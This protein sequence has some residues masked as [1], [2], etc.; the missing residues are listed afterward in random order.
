MAH[1][2]VTLIFFKTPRVVCHLSSRPLAS[3]APLYA[4]DFV[5]T[6]AH[7]VWTKGR[8]SC[9]PRSVK[10]SQES[11]ILLSGART[12][13]PNRKLRASIG[14]LCHTVSRSYWKPAFKMRELIK[15]LE[16]T[17]F[18]LSHKAKKKVQS[19][20]DLKRVFS[21]M[22]G[23]G[24]GVVVMLGQPGIWVRKAQAVWGPRVPPS[25]T[26]LDADF[27]IVWNWPLGKP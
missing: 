22:V 27:W 2:S 13:G 26:E 24:S 25:G 10:C 9:L 20:P 7:V 4:Q 15:L 12:V 23:R 8:Q 16:S 5:W 14:P 19:W 11:T 17:C 1:H 6:V 18:V 21:R 3:T